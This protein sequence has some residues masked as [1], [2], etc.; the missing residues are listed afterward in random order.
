ME[1]RQRG[2]SNSIF[3]LETLHSITRSLNNNAEL[4]ARSISK[5]IVRNWNT[6]KMEEK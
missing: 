6:R 4:T 2:E 3:R 5:S 1:E